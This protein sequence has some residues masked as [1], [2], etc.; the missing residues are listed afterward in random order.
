MNSRLLKI[1]KMNG[2][3]LLA[4][5]SSVKKNSSGKMRMRFILKAEKKEGA[6][7][8]FCSYG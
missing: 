1:M 3:S 7:K 5:V 2:Y 4:Q 8:C 6:R